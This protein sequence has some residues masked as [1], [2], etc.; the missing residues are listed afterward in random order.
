MTIGSAFATK[1]EQLQATEETRSASLKEYSVNVAKAAQ[2]SSNNDGKA[3]EKLSAKAVAA[4][5]EAASVRLSISD[6]TVGVEG[7]SEQPLVARVVGQ[8]AA[9]KARVDKELQD[10]DIPTFAP[11]DA[12][13]AIAL[14]PQPLAWF[15]AITIETLPLVLMGLLLALWREEEP[16]Q[17]AEDKDD[18]NVVDIDSRRSP[19][20]FRTPAE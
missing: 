12:K 3:F 11:V 13:Q 8:V 17:Q 14:N 9:M 5:T 15:T 20:S 16:D 2:A 6:I 10:V 19:N 7:G 4:L 1:A 18:K